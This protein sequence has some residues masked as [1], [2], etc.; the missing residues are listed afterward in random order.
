MYKIHPSVY[1]NADPALLELIERAQ[2]CNLSDDELIRYEAGLKALEDTIDF[3]EMLAEA[4]AEM[5]VE[6]NEA[7]EESNIAKKEAEAI[8][9]EVEAVKK[10]AEVAK[11][12]AKRAKEK[13]AEASKFSLEEG[14][15]KGQVE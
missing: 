5:Q 1:E 10:E 11:N 9:T 14:R 6:I 4:K 3:D 2:V 7:K 12:E 13:L 15:T 8:K